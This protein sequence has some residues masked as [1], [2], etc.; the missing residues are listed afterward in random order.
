MS[1]FPNFTQVPPHVNARISER[2]GNPKKVSSLNSWIRVSSANGKGLMLYSNPNISTFKKA[3]DNNMASIYGNGKV[4]GILGTDWSGNAIYANTGQGFKPSPVISSIEVD[5]GAGDLSRKATFSIT[6]FT[7]EQMEK[8]LEYFLEPGYTVFLEWGWNTPNS[9]IGWESSLTADGVAKFQSF[10]KVNERRAAT[11]GEYDNY[12]GFITGGGLS[13]EGDK[14]SISVQL[15][16]FTELPGYMGSTENAEDKITLDGKMITGAFTIEPAPPF[17]ANFIENA[18]KAGELGKERFMRMFNALPDSRKTK[19][20][21]SLISSLSKIENF[22][23]WDADVAEQINGETE[24]GFWA[25]EAKKKIGNTEVS[26]PRGTKLISDNK[27]IRFGTMMDIFFEIGQNGF[28][29]SNDKTINFRVKTS[30]TYCMAFDHMYSL[31]PSILYIPNPKTP[32]FK[33]SENASGLDLTD[34]GTQDN[35]EGLN[36]IKFPNQN[37]LDET[38]PKSGAHIK[39]KKHF[40]G[41]LDDL[42]VNF[43]FVKNILETKNITTKDAL[44]QILNGMSSA[45]NGLW[46]FQIVEKESETSDVSELTVIDLNF[47]SSMSD[48]IDLTMNTIGEQS[49]LIDSSL[50]LDISAAKMNSIVGQRLSTSLNGHGKAVPATLFSGNTDMVLTQM[51]EKDPVEPLPTSTKAEEAD[52][53]KQEALDVLLGKLFLYPFVTF[54]EA[55]EVKDKDLYDICYVGAY[56]DVETFAK[57]KKKELGEI[58]GAGALMPIQFSFKIHG[59]SGIKRGDMFRINGLPSMYEAKG[60]FFQTLSVKHT[61]EGMQ[62]TTEITGGFRPSNNPKIG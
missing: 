44:Y 42:Y 51:D 29:L 46:D 40:W 48:G 47:V 3:G 60:S 25:G 22:I 10:T 59:I 28:K 24:G 20:V 39:Q 6:A 61:I 32:K 54:K 9:V 41:K 16:G 26:L 38:N 18:G 11:G 50:D 52:V 45:V 34:D 23:N 5:E 21:Q 53:K 14:W 17:G 58:I 7:K 27:F 57:I 36:G 37:D 35:S 1:D 19:R 4:S 8:L 62:W 2:I 56:K 49:I 31:D 30:K 43:D 13:Q 55:S 15:T 12:L 33:V